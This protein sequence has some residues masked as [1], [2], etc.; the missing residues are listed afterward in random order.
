[1]KTEV[2]ALNGLHCPSCARLVQEEAAKL[3]G[4][5]KA[6]VDLASQQLRLVYDENSLQFATLEAAITAAGFGVRRPPG[7]GGA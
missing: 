4:V 1:M 5:E 7:T 3:E 6:V 2:F